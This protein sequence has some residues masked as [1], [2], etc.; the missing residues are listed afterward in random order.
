M[1]SI[2]EAWAGQNFA[3][4]R[5]SSQGDLHKAYSSFPINTNVFDSNAS[6]SNKSYS[7]DLTRGM[8]SSNSREPRVSSINSNSDNATISLS[9][10]MPSQNTYTGL[11]PRP[12]YMQLYDNNNIGTNSNDINDNNYFGP[13]PVDSKENFTDIN[14]AYSVSD[15]IRDF[16]KIGTSASDNR[17][18]SSSNSSRNS[19]S[20]SNSNSN[21]SDLLTED[22]DTDIKI[23]NTK[24]NNQNNQ[25]NQNNFE[26]IQNKHV[27]KYDS[28]DG[29]LPLLTQAST[30]HSNY[31]SDVH[32]SIILRDILFKLDKIEHDIAHTKSRNM[33]DIIL[34]MLIGM[35]IS[36][37]IYSIF[38]NTK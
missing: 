34:Y 32:I 15:T 2:E 12:G 19:N 14:S 27:S 9:S 18:R 25:N 38:A 20:R 22:T 35:M 21:I 5:V 16:M 7:N 10:S 8:N 23:I 30:P 33:Y 17:S 4:K 29:V 24:I 3:D 13:S 37:I 6:Y 36:F 11:N 28:S 26:N 1:C 31:S